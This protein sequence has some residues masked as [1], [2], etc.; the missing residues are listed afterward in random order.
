MKYMFFT[1]LA[2]VLF[3]LN[4]VIYVGTFKGWGWGWG[5]GCEGGHPINL[6][7]VI[8]T[9]NIFLFL[10]DTEYFPEKEAFPD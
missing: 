9:W 7:A 8:A 4:L 6:I 10:L 5:W 2:L 1:I 3:V